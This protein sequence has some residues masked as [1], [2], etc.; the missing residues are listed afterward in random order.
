V[1]NL[2]AMTGRTAEGLGEVDMGEAWRVRHD[3]VGRERAA[4][5]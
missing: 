1:L 4:G 2:K 5:D 3:D